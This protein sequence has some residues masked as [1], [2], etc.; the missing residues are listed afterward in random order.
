M[1]EHVIKTLLSAFVLTI[2]FC[3]TS[4]VFAA[5][6]I[7]LRVAESSIPDGYTQPLSDELQQ[8]RVERID[9]STLDYVNGGSITKAV[10]VYLPAEYD[11]PEN[12]EKKYDILYFMHGYSG[13]A[14]ELFGFHNGANKNILDHMIANG[15]ITPVIV[16]AATWN[17]SPDTPTNNQVV[18]YGTGDGT[19]QREAFWQDFRNDLM[20]SIEGKYRTWADLS[21]SDTKESMNEKLMSSRS[22]RAFSGFSF[23]GV[24][25]WW[26]FRDNFDYIRDFAPFSAYTSA[27]ISE[28]EQAVANT[29]SG[30]SSFRIFSV[31]GT[32]D[33][34]AS[35]NTST[36]DS[37]FR[38]PV[39]GVHAAYYILQGAAH[40]FEGYQRYLYLTLKEFYHPIEQ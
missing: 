19:A 8:G 38:S 22:H 7:V 11:D 13:T 23:G 24:T 9:Y 15:E 14:Y 3:M 34:I 21:E 33:V 30:D 40:D 6:Q 2:T 31:T 18:W 28:L 37:I 12:E 29:D 4:C 20:P 32:D 25:T 5:D 39:L 17:V 27:S 26:Q 16:V 36:M 35:M 1:I 10:F